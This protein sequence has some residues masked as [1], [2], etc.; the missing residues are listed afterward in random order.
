[1]FA[2]T[3]ASLHYKYTQYSICSA[4]SISML[5]SLNNFCCVHLQHEALETPQALERK[6]L[7]QAFKLGSHGLVKIAHIPYISF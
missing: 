2:F 5:L 1:M 4:Y 6:A 7:Q 3:P